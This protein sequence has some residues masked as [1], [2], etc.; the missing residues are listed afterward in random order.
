MTKR[1]IMGAEVL[2]VD[3]FKP[4]KGKPLAKQVIMGAQG[5]FKPGNLMTKRVIMGAEVLDGF[6]TW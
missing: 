1:V 5:G 6:Q 3:G 4:G 2:M